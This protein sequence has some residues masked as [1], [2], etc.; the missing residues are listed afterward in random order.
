M[1]TITQLAKNWQVVMTEKAEE[2]AKRTGFVVKPQKITGARFAQ[3]LVWGWLHEPDMRLSGLA[4]MF[5]NSQRQAISRQALHARFNGRA[6]HFME[7]LLGEALKS[8]LSVGQQSQQSPWFEQFETVQIADS[9]IIRFPEAV[10]ALYPG[11][12][13][14]SVKILV[15]ADLKYGSLEQ[16]S[17]HPG[18]CHDQQALSEQYSLPA[19][20]LFMADLGFSKLSRFAKIHAAKSYWLSRYK[21][22]TQLY[23]ADG[24]E[25]DLLQRL[26]HQQQLD[27][28]VYAG[29]K[30]RLPSRLLALPVSDA[31]YQQRLAALAD[32]ERRHQRQAS[33]TRRALCRWVI[34]L[35]NLSEQQLSL[36]QVSI[37]YRLRWQIE[38]LFK[39][40]K[41][42]LGLD[43]WRTAN[44]WRML[45]E[46]YAKLLAV[47]FTHGVMLL[48][49][50]HD[51]VYSSVQICR[52]IQRHAWTLARFFYKPDRFLEELRHLR[53]CLGNK[54]IVSTSRSSPP[55]HQLMSA[56][57]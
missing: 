48:T 19:N 1:T 54:P 30:E 25:L 29:K 45:C 53:F 33:A 10:Q 21:G 7:C 56:N 24:Q 40:W 34:Y 41:S 27:I 14:S 44:P 26:Q 36:A 23:T 46:F 5:V 22:G 17:L 47:L 28:T 20:S 9:T 31:I 57:F 6:A 18:R 43:N 52:T 3:T 49:G 32:W 35:T 51:L 42:E 38:L 8:V 12:E 2:W 55:T 13:S 11:T 15:V 37:A 4:D 50:G 16:V 39:L